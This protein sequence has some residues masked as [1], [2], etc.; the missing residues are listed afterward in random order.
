MD[1]AELKNQNIMKI[2][3]SNYNVSTKYGILSQLNT[4]KDLIICN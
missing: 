4:R 2:T 1:K 3:I